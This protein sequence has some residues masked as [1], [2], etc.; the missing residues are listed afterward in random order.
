M[1]LKGV[2][3]KEADAPNANGT[4]YSKEALQSIEKQI[5]E[6]GEIYGELGQSFEIFHHGIDIR[7]IV[8]KTTSSEYIDDKLFIDV[9]ILPT[10]SSNIIPKNKNG[11]YDLSEF[12]FGMRGYADNMNDDIITDFTLVSIDLIKKNDTIPD[13]ITEDIIPFC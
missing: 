6:S 2:F 1:K 11:E 9:E 5:N 4:I 7:N 3:L 13:D 12:T 8:T 10:S